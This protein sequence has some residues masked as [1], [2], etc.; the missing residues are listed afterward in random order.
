[1]SVLASSATQTDRVA[2]IR[3][4]FLIG[5]GTLVST[6]SQLFHDHF[7][8]SPFFYLEVWSTLPAWTA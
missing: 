8:A 3:Y 2:L 1:M 7:A 5:S 4:Y 6:G